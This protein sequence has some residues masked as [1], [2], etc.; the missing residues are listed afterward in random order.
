MFPESANWRRTLAETPDYRDWE[1]TVS[2]QG[3]ERKCKRTP[4]PRLSAASL[5]KLFHPSEL[6]DCFSS[7]ADN[8][9]KYSKGRIRA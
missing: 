9:L 7:M 3:Y 2:C 4:T 5:K 8:M 1:M 6:R